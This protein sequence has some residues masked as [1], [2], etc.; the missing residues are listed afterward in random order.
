MVRGREGELE[1]IAGVLA[2]GG[3]L[4]VR[5]GPGSGKTTLL[6]EAGAPRVLRASGTRSESA[7]PYAGLQQLLM[8]I[9]TGGT[10]ERALAAQPLEPHERMAA[11]LELLE[12]LRGEAPVAVVVDDAHLLDTASAD[13][14]AFVARRLDGADVAVLLA[15]RP[16]GP[17]SLRD[18][19]ELALPAL[20]EA[21]ARELVPADAAPHVREAI[22]ALAAGNPLALAELPGMLTR[23]QLTGSEPL[24]DPLPVGPRVRAMYPDTFPEVLVLAAL[25]ETGDPAVL[26][27]DPDGIDELEQTGVLRVAGGRVEI[28]A[29]LR[30]AIDAGLTSRRRREAHLALAEVLA[31]DRRAWHRALAAEAPDEA[32]AGELEREA[33]GAAR[34]RG[35]ATAGAMLERAAQ[36]TSDGPARAR[37]LVAAAEAQWLAGRTERVGLLLAQAEALPGDPEG[38]AS[39]AM[40]RGTAEL[41]AGSPAEAYDVLLAG[42]RQAAGEESDARAGHAHARGRGELD[43]RAHGG[44]RG[45]RRPRGAG[46]LR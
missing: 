10:L 17:A 36:L 44:D 19:P 30:A 18:L 24:P 1:Q 31:G 37:R 2:D 11:S 15:A 21:A 22:V 25:D 39:A 7:L 42:A 4:V 3:A 13:A 6:A 40:L 41:D 43:V 20:P 16:G 26:A 32:L 28:D 27:R 38:R 46:R 34:R 45:P 33:P 5:G 35:H 23:A 9:P 29:L 14:L 12:L 8:G